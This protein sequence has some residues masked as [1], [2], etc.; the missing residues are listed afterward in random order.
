[1][2]KNKVLIP[3]PTIKLGLPKP[4]KAGFGQARVCSYPSWYTHVESGLGPNHWSACV[5]YALILLKCQGPKKKKFLLI[6]ATNYNMMLIKAIY[7]Y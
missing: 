5:C 2:I 7:C 3:N 6:I 1:M 4:Q